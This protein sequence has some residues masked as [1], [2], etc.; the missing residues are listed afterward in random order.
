LIRVEAGDG[1]SLQFGSVLATNLD[2]LRH[3]LNSRME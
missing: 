1:C 2:H 3:S